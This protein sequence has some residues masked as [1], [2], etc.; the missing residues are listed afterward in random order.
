MSK[1]QKF[2][3]SNGF[4]E[5]S[6]LFALVF[7]I[8]LG[9]F[10]LISKNHWV[11]IPVQ[12]ASVSIGAIENSPVPAESPKVFNIPVKNKMTI[13]VVTPT[14]APTIQSSLTPQS[15]PTIVYQYVSTPTSTPNGILCNGIYWNQCPVGQNFVCPADGNAYCQTLE[16]QAAQ[17]KQDRINQLTVTYNAQY[18]SLQ[19]KIIDIKTKYYA[20]IAGVQSRPIPSE[21]Q[22][23][24]IQKLTDDANTKIQQ[25]QLQEQQLYLNYTVQLNAL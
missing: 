2:N 23:G 14:I 20:D 10:F 25:I 11:N 1:R 12:E 22:Q 5:P 17:Q 9:T 24:Q 15:V 7:L 8:S 19:Q 3:F 4:L 6:I 21:F 13:L 18:V 16:Q